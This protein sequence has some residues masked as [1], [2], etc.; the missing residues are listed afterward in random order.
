[1]ASPRARRAYSLVMS[2][3][4]H[5][6]IVV[7]LTFSLPLSAPQRAG[8]PNVEPIQ[9][10]MISAAEI[11]TAMAAIEAEEEAARQQERERQE[12]IE[13]EQQAEVERAEAAREAELEA[14]RVAQREAE[15][16]AAAE[17]ERIRI[18]QEQQA[19]QERVAREAAER[20]QREREAAEAREREREL[21]RQREE[22]LAQERAAEQ[23]RQR[24]EAE[25]RARAVADSVLAAAAAEEAQRAAVSAAESSG[26]K[27]QWIRQ[28]ENHI[29]RHWTKPPSAQA[30]IVCVLNVNWVITG[31]VQSVSIGDCNGNEAVRRSIQAAVLEASPLPRPPVPGLFQRNLIITFAPD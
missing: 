11:D 14:Q 21:E 20:E 1:M 26:Q 18:Q 31:D 22:Q 10:V 19:E 7:A 3:L 29:V 15:Q 9:A 13:R 5:A 28:I 30:G 16:E 8:S 25:A 17:A 2:V 24:R 6:A 12:Q 27:D 23:E 4:A